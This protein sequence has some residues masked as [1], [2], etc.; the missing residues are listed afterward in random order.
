MIS[1]LVFG[2]LWVAFPNKLLQ[3]NFDKSKYDWITVHMTQAFGLFCIY[4]AVPSYLAYKKGDKSYSKKVLMGKTITLLLL[5]LLMLTA[6][7]T[8]QTS[9]AKFGMLG[10]TISIIINLIGIYN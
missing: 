4:S 5:L 8:I 1:W 7:K 6:N 2:V 3:Y 10:L 9:H